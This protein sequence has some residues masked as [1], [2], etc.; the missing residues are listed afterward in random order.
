M[1]IVS[2]PTP[3]WIL[4]IIVFSQFCCTSLWF[5]GNGVMEDLAAAFHF[6]ANAQGHLTSAVQFGFIVGTLVFALLSLADRYPPSRVFFF[7]AVVAAMANAATIFDANSLNSLLIL[8]ACTG[9]FL[10]GIYPVGMKIAA[11]YFQQGL[12]KSLGYLVGALVLGTSFPHLVKGFS[13]ELPWRFV[14]LLTSVLAILGGTLMLI[15]VPDGPF[16]KRGSKID[17]SIAAGV[18]KVRPFRAAAFG[19]FG[20]MW[21]LY[22]FWAFVPFMLT[23]Y[24]Q[25][26]PTQSF[27]VSLVAFIIIGC[28]GLACVVSGYL[29]QRIG[30]KTTATLALS[31]SLLCCLLSP[32]LF[33]LSSKFFFIGGLL[34]W[35]LVVIADSPMLSTLVAQNAAQETKGTALTIVNCI[36]FAITIFSIQLL[37]QL[38]DSWNPIYL[39]WVLVPGPTFGLLALYRKGITTRNKHPE[40]SH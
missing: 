16:R 36:G 31:L 12:G 20:H 39:Y 11:D 18:F 6:A 1:K 9:F 30:A 25:L 3:K 10:A 15:L 23:T 22:A 2:T 32:L 5:A 13:G 26:H 27:S 21:E 19:Y 40:A 14:L 38:M 17:L 4:S 29:S 7:S 28:G 24:Q 33:Q 8:R 37:T 35:G 34:F